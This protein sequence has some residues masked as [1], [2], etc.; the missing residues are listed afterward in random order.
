MEAPVSSSFTKQDGRLFPG[1]EPL[2]YPVSPEARAAPIKGRLPPRTLS[3]SLGNDNRVSRQAVMVEGRL[4]FRPLPSIKGAVT[5][6][7]TL[8]RASAS[9][10][11]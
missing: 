8:P 7:G 10:R 9:G 3:S 1:P 5:A 2:P 6:H 4:P 11:H